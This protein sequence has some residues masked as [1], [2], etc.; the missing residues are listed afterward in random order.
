LIWAETTLFGFSF[1]A[2]FSVFAK[3]SPL[4]PVRRYDLFESAEW[5]YELK[6]DD[7][8]ALAYIAERLASAAKVEPAILVIHR[9]S[10]Q[11]L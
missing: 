9:S 6:H 1:V 8:R 2:P 4:V 5:I 7:F 11:L 3:I 10:P